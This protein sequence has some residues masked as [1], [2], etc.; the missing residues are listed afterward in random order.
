[1]AIGHFFEEG[2]NIWR[3]IQS[4]GLLDFTRD[5][6]LSTRQKG[7]LIVQIVETQD[8]INKVSGLGRGRTSMQTN[9]SFENRNVTDFNISEISKEGLELRVRGL[10]HHSVKKLMAGSLSL[11]QAVENRFKLRIHEGILA[12]K[13]SDVKPG[14][15]RI[16]LPTTPLSLQFRVM[17]TIILL[18]I[19]NVF[20]TAAWY[21][22]LRFKETALWKVIFISWL[23]TFAEYCFQ[24]PANRF[25]SYQFSTAQLKTIQEVITLLVFCIFSVIYL[26]E[27]LKWNYIVGFLFII[28]AVFFVFKKW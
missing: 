2:S 26:K 4:Q 8:T 1:M 18:T 10:L 5:P 24:V 15:R 23:I 27:E 7:N 28:G 21:G 17:K 16:P 11:Q 3:R 22:H 14:L 25:G 19:S 13:R 6:R 20:M 9:Q 12:Q